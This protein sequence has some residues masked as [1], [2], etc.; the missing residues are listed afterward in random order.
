[1]DILLFRSR[2]DDN[3]TERIIVE[4]KR[5]TVQVGKKELDQIKSYARAVI[6]NPQYR[7]VNCKWRVYLI[8][9]DYAPT[10]LR[11]IRQRDKPEGL[12][13]DQDDYEVWV[14][15]WG[16]ILD[17]AEKKLLFFQRQLDYD[18]T[19]QRVTQHLRDSYAHFIPDTLHR[20]AP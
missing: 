12:C 4:L 11:D 14:K 3:S 7:G 1:M 9:Y 18:A 10:I 2:R 6:D 17:S 15:S 13:D 16:E 19:D 5:P 20:P 8:T